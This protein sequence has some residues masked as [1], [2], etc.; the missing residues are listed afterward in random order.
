MLEVQ[1]TQISLVWVVA[2][3]AL[4]ALVVGFILG[5]LFVG[6]CEGWR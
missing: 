6:W 3:Y 2:G 5:V 1:T 4:A